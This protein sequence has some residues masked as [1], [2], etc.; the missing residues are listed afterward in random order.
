MSNK[1]FRSHIIGIVLLLV[2]AAL[3]LEGLGALTFLT[4]LTGGLSVPRLVIGLLLIGIASISC[5]RHPT[6]I[7]WYLALLFMLFESNIAYLCGRE[8]PNLIN[9]WLVL[10]CSILIMIALHLLLGPEKWR[11]HPHSPHHRHTFS[12][13]SSATYI[14]CTDFQKKHIENNLGATDIYFTN[15][16]S[17]TGGG[18]LSVENNLGQTTIRV[19]AAWSISLETENNLGAIDAPANAGTHSGPLL[20]LDVENN[21]GHVIITYI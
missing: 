21:L 13:G 18:T 1:K 12:S 14:D 3:I 16:E 19:P 15:I 5:R 17:Y 9:N 2:A 6:R 8:E 10:L 20:Y 7:V 11:F 4:E